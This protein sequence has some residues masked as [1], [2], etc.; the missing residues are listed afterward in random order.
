MWKLDDQKAAL[1]YDGSE[2]EHLSDYILSN[3]SFIGLRDESLLG[4][5]AKCQ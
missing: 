4:P 1:E 3:T 5:G 2:A